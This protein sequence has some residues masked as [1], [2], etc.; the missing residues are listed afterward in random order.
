MSEQAVKDNLSNYQGVW[1]FAEQRDGVCMNT[2][3]ELIGEG[4]K[5]ADDL[6]VELAA[7]LLGSDIQKLAAELLQYGV[8]RVLLAEHELL[9]T[10]TTDGYTTALAQL[11][12]ARKPEVV[13]IGATNIGRDLGPRLAARL[14]TGLTADCTQL[15]IDKEKRILLQT[16]PA[17]GGN[18]M[19]TIITPNNRPQMSTVRPGVFVKSACVLKP[20]G[21]VE[22]VKVDLKPED[23]HTKVREVVKALKH[24]VNLTEADVIVSGG[25]GLGKAEGFELI[26]QLADTLDGVVGSSRAAVDAGWISYDHQVGQT[27]KS[28]R[29]KLYIACGI[30]GAIQHLAGMQNSHCIVAINKNPDAPILKVADY[31]IV[32]DLYKVIPLLIDEVNRAKLA[33]EAPCAPAI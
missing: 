10:Y 28:V 22:T 6:G 29:P 4:R 31:G 27:G 21:V 18:V 15:D 30:S 5:L 8:D 3:F 9:K 2:T 24:A 23:I 26:Q 16:R 19:A 7:V 25:R 33:D 17:F 12:T 20:S 13:L 1:I 32:G 14:N 11:I